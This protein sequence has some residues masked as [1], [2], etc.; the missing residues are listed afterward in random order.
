MPTMDRC[1]CLR[2]EG[3]VWTITIGPEYW[4]D[5][6]SGWMKSGEERRE[7]ERFGKW[8]T[9]EPTTEHGWVCEVI[10]A[11]EELS[12]V[13]KKM[14]VKWFSRKKLKSAEDERWSEKLC[15]RSELHQ[16]KVKIDIMFVYQR[17]PLRKSWEGA[18]TKE[19]KNSKQTEKC[20]KNKRN[21]V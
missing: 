10:T 4:D 8:S 21:R 1:R 13:K 15:E 14:I 18:M 6:E 17:A 3:I 11:D 12:R 20:L 16:M 7:C 5:I 9:N 2:I 19:W